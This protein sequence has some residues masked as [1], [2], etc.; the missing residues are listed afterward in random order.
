MSKR[1]ISL[2]LTGLLISSFSL[3]ADDSMDKNHQEMRQLKMQQAELAAKQKLLH[4]K[5]EL[6]LK[7][8]QLKAWEVYQANLLKNA[9]KKNQ[10]TQDLRKKH[11]DSNT[12]PTSLDLAKININRLELRLTT[13]KSQFKALEVFYAQLDHEQQ[14]KIDKMMHRKIQKEAKRLRSNK[15][16]KHNKP[17]R[18]N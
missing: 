12:K 16:P 2:L 18:E 3:I 7:E 10:I 14:A 8:S 11:K 6:N 9:G 15:Q 1:L 17:Q 13:A 5:Q 4:L